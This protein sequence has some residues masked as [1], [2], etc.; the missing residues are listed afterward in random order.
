MERSKNIRAIDGQ[1]EG[2]QS[3]SIGQRQSEGL[4]AISIGQR[5]MDTTPHR[6]PAAL[7]AASHPSCRRVKTLRWDMPSLRDCAGGCE[8]KAL[9]DYAIGNDVDSAKSVRTYTWITPS[10]ATLTRGYQ[11][12][13][14]SARALPF[15][16]LITIFITNF[17]FITF[18]FITLF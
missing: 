9:R 5:P 8:A 6:V 4:Q 1:S 17:K 15:T 3:V 11:C 2:Q 12:P 7:R 18:N 16:P 14:P 13:T 10:Y